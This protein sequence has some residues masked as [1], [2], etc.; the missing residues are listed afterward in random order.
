MLRE[1]SREKIRLTVS[2]DMVA[3]CRV[4]S[5]EHLYIKFHEGGDKLTLFTALLLSQTR[6]GITVATE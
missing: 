4:I 2:I 1:S 5:S 3:G 6:D